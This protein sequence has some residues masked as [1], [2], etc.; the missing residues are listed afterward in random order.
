MSCPKLAGDTYYLDMQRRVYS[1]RMDEESRV[2]VS[3]KSG[4][5]AGGTVGQRNHL[6]FV[7]SLFV[8]FMI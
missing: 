8:L 5:R 2:A 3:G 1:E 6:F 4:E 7:I